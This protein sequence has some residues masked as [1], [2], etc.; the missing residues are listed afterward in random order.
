MT[1]RIQTAAEKHLKVTVEDI[2]AAEMV[3]QRQ[4]SVRNGKS[5]GGSEGEIMGSEG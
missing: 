2:S 3:R 5:K 1:W 4:E